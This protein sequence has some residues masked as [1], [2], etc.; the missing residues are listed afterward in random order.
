MRLLFV[1]E[2]ICHYIGLVSDPG[3]IMETA[4]DVVNLIVP[5]SSHKI[6]STHKMIM[7]LLQVRLAVTFHQ[8]FCTV[9]HASCSR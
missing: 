4:F 8:G 1:L 5:I 6:E 2:V 9:P 3:L 7:A